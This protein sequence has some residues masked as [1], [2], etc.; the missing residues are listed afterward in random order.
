[1]LGDCVVCP[2][3]SILQHPGNQT[4]NSKHKAWVSAQS[5]PAQTVKTE[6][7]Q[8]HYNQSL[9]FIH[10]FL[11][12]HSLCPFL[13]LFALVVSPSVHSLPLSHTHTDSPSVTAPSP[14]PLPPHTLLMSLRH[15][16]STAIKQTHA[17]RVVHKCSTHTQDNHCRQP[18]YNPLSW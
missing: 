12:L 16:C 5:Y 7:L 2:S 6:T 13:S 15:T 4:E 14:S 3:P 11:F 1:M 10:H 17:L 8:K 9:S 18:S